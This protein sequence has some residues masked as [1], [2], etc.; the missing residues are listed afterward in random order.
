MTDYAYATVDE[1]IANSERYCKREGRIWVM[2]NK[3]GRF[4][5]VNPYSAQTEHHYR[6]VLGWRLAAELRTVTQVERF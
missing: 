5:I 6:V 3:D 1:A 4:E 2:E